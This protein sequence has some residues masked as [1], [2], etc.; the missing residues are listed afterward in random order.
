MS[1]ASHVTLALAT[2][3]AAAPAAWAGPVDL[4]D[5]VRAETPLAEEIAAACARYCQ[6]N[7]RA[8]TLRRVTAERLDAQHVAMSGEAVL[9]SRQ[10]QETPVLLGGALGG[11]VTL[12]DYAVTVEVD[13][14]LD[15]S[16]CVLEVRRLRVVN[17]RFG[18]ADRIRGR[19]AGPHH[20]PDCDHLLRGM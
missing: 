1:R 16:V 17:D 2:A 4:T 3:L 12:F 13:G 11:P 10:V 8:G 6:G 18:L 7:R 5:R 9:R 19:L 15:L 14:I 20:V